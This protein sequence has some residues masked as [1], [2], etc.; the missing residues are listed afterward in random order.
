V[1][2][3]SEL[4]QPLGILILDTDDDY[5]RDEDAAPRSI[6]AARIT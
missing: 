4:L 6:P 5:A 3:G 2:P 1:A